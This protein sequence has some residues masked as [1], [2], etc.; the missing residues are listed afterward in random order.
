[1]KTKQFK[2]TAKVCIFLSGVLTIFR[3]FLS[4]VQAELTFDQP[5]PVIGNKNERI[6]EITD[7]NKDLQKKVDGL[8]QKI[9]QN[10]NG[11]G[12]N[13]KDSIQN[14]LMSL[15]DDLKKVQGQIRSLEKSFSE[16]ALK[17]KN[18]EDEVE[19]LKNN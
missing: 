14:L 7:Q 13:D 1:M 4:S 17:Q 3:L 16:Y 19:K 8:E 11:A 10:T 15:Q 2:K 18:L 6:Q 9:I 12:G 5:K